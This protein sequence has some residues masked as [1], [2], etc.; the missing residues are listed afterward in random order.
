MA[1]KRKRVAVAK[2]AVTVGKI[3]CGGKLS[4][5]IIPKNCLWRRTFNLARAHKLSP[6]ETQREDAKIF[7][8]ADVISLP[9]V[10][11]DGDFFEALE[12]FADV[13]PKF[14]VAGTGRMISG[15]NV[16]LGGHIL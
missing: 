7:K 6:D 8:S 14:G 4:R 16:F 5:S 2:A 1:A 10:Q 12:R 13:H 15:F 3:I 9:A 11:G